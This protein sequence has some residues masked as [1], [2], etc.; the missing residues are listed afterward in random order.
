MLV[1]DRHEAQLSD[2]DKNHKEPPQD[3]YDRRTYLTKLKKIEWSLRGSLGKSQRILPDLAGQARERH[4]RES[5]RGGGREWKGH[6][7]RSLQDENKTSR[8]LTSPSC[9]DQ[10]TIP[11]K[12]LSMFSDFL[13]FSSQHGFLRLSSP[14]LYSF[15]K[16]ALKMIFYKRF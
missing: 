13:I 5:R 11:T 3:V 4:G 14:T 15:A 1:Q 9:Q 12:F 16:H 7:I 8:G 6:S 10:D 2:N